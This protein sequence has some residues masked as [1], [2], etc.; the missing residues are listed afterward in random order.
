MTKK[1]QPSFLMIVL[2]AVCN[3]GNADSASPAA[4]FS[5]DGGMD[6]QKR[7]RVLSLSLSLDACSTGSSCS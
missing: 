4:L 5:L 2:M 1:G 6:G 3:D 7:V